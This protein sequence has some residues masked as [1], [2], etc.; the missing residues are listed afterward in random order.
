MFSL[1]SS[2]GMFFLLALHALYSSINQ[3]INSYSDGERIP[4]NI[5]SVGSGS[6]FAYGVLDQGYRLDHY[7]RILRCEA[8][9]EITLPVSPLF[10]RPFAHQRK[11]LIKGFFKPAPLDLVLLFKYSFPLIAILCL[12][13]WPAIMFFFFQ[14]K[15]Q[16]MH[17][18][19]GWL[20]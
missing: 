8:T 6:I 5:F 11:S 18:M 9:L 16:L 1:C 17:S 15:I 19:H 13:G 4:G 20:K 2:D 12:V 10:A 14:L 7:F 3:W